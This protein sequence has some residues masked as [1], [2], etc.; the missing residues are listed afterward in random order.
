MVSFYRMTEYF[1]NLIL[2]TK[3][4]FSSDVVVD[5]TLGPSLLGAFVELD[6]RLDP[7]Q[8]N[9]VGSLNNRVIFETVD[10]EE[11]GG[12][13]GEPGALVEGLRPATPYHFRCR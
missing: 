13:G 1:T 9:T 5:T 11:G 2:L 8:E 10:L 7:S 12:G 3:K 4:C 6:P